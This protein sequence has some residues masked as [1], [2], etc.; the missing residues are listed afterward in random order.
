[1]V[2][3][4]LSG[5]AMPTLLV[6]AMLYTLCTLVVSMTTSDPLM[7]KLK[8][9]VDAQTL[10]TSVVAKLRPSVSI[11]LSLGLM[12]VSYNMNVLAVLVMPAG[13]TAIL[14]VPVVAP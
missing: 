9:V 1:M 14:Q 3:L 5:L 7:T 4:V 13:R 8:L 6:V 10:I 12:L 2:M 11:R